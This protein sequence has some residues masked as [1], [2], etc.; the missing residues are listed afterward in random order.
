[1]LRLVTI[2]LA[3]A[4]IGLFEA[5]E[6]AVLALLPKHGGRLEMRLR[7][8]DGRNETHLLHFPDGQAFERYRA[9]PARLVLSGDWER[10][11]ARSVGF[12]VER[13][14]DA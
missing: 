2:D 7:A 9:D 4:D 12:E 8:L 14:E 11:R 6:A 1:M 10:S 5:Y 3:E 13:I